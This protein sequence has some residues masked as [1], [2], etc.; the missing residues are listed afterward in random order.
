M[1]E[2]SNE[3]YDRIQCQINIVIQKLSIQQDNNRLGDDISTAIESL[4]KLNDKLQAELEKLKENSEWKCFTI[5]F[6][7]ETNA[8]KSTLIEA[9]RLQL[10]EKTKRENQKIFKELQ[11]QLGLTQKEFDDVR[12]TILNAE[13]EIEIVHQEISELLE[14]YVVPIMKAELAVREIEGKNAQEYAQ[15]VEGHSIVI[16][17]LE[18]EIKKLNELIKLFQAERNWIQ[19][20]I[21]FFSP[22]VEKLQLSKLI[23]HF[24][25]IKKQQDIEQKNII[26]HHQNLKQETENILIELEEKK[27]QEENECFQKEKKL[28]DELRKAEAEKQRLDNEAIKLAD[29]ADG[30][31][32]GDGRSDFTRKNTSF[33][34]DLGGQ[35]FSLIDVPG[36]EGDED[37]VGIPIEEAIR[38]AHAVFYVTRTARPPQTNDGKDGSKKGTLEK[39][40]QHLG[41]QTEVWS[42]YNHPAK[43]PRQLTSPLLNE[44]N[45]KSLA[46]MDE[47]LQAELKEQYYGSIVVSAR[48]A[49]LALTECIIPG[50]KE[51]AEQ[52]KFLERFGNTQTILS[53]SGITDF[54]TRLQTTIVGDYRNKIEC[55]NLNKAYKKLEE[56]LSELKCFQNKFAILHKD[57]KQEVASANSRINVALEE[58]SASLSAVASKIRQTFRRQVEEEIYDDIQRDIS[59]DAFKRYLKYALEQESENIKKDLKEMIEKETDT[60]SEK[61]REIIDRSS[62]HL[63]NI[64]QMQSNNIEIHS[65]FII[66]INVDNGLKIGGLVASGI[67]G[68]L[69]IVFLASNP[70]G[71]TLAFVGGAIALVGSI[72]GIAKSVWG[73][74]DSDYKKSQQRKETDKIL[75]GAND[76][77][78]KEINKIIRQIQKEMSAE[79]QKIQS[80]LEEPVRQCAAINLSLKQADNELTDIARNIKG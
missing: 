43:S 65:D 14:K 44:D 26:T 17:E 75:H 32:I 72:V 6:Y 22:P 67:G 56:S 12:Y 13:K 16:N 48:P 55:S 49:Y 20:I 61:V 63:K 62:Q 57:I 42:I 4:N 52:R 51:A 2:L 77:I 29:F 36:I 24:S 27:K 7:G 11:Q 71:W 28:Q 58:F 74:F 54:V 3:I 59:N 73:F 64:V 40:K 33:D 38:K 46:V 9:L 21:A 35:S 76:S 70:V 5:A 66:N 18:S 37:I 78:E 31:I 60:F 45:Y 47:K 41:S 69:G 34:F 15:L 80:E 79:M 68:A 8:G 53:L 19:K 30:Q 1:S 39:I 10:G 23:T 50:S 25:Q